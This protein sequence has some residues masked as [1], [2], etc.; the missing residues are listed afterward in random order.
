MHTDAG[1]VELERL[2]LSPGQAKDVETEVELPAVEL[3]G[4]TYEPAGG[5]AEARLDVSRT[6][7]GYAL[8]LRYE[9]ELA[10]PCVR[11]LEPARIEL[12]VDA[13]EVDQPA[14]R[15]EEL[16]SPY[17]SDEGELDLRRW[18]NDAM[19]LG[20]PSQPL[21]REDCAGL[22]AVCG[23]SLNDA[24]PEAHQHGGGGDPR[25]AKLRDLKLE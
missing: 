9:T 13:R 7:T 23:E 10:G 20:L 4:Q 1:I 17:V 11:C 5:G 22:C 8:R 12:G 15:D 6:T 24:D 3:G 14:T 21:C 25:M 2:S 19:V 18:A 16:R